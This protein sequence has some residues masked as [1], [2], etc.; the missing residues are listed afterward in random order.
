[1]FRQFSG[2]TD[3]GYEGGVEAH[4]VDR[5]DPSESERERGW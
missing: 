3:S 4:L 5:I 1:M 2:I